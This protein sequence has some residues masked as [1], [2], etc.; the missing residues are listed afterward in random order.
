MRPV[1]PDRPWPP[2]QPPR[3]WPHLYFMQQNQ[4]LRKTP[5]PGAH[6]MGKG[7]GL[8]DSRGFRRVAD[9]FFTGLSTAN[10]DTFPAP[11]AQPTVLPVT[12]LSSR[13]LLSPE[14]RPG[15][16]VAR[17]PQ[18]AHR[19]RP[20]YPK[21]RWEKAPARRLD[22][23][24]FTLKFLG[25]WGCHCPFGGQGDATRPCR[26]LG[27]VHPRVIPRVIHRFRG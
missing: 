5:T 2:A 9:S 6:S 8:R 22:K 14:P 1:V 12:L 26:P 15:A 4:H 24:C 23:K 27:A 7:V 10:G 19:H 17:F 11:G 25:T 3:A 13:C 21:K 16:T 18:A 20:G